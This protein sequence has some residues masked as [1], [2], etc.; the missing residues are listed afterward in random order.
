MVNDFDGFFASEYPLVV[1]ALALALGDRELAEDAAQEGFARALAHWATVSTKDR[2]TTWVYVVAM[3]RARDHL[4]HIARRPAPAPPAGL[5]D[6]A[7]AVATAVTVRAAIADLTPRQR[8]AVVLRYL[9][10]LT[11]QEM[12]VAMGCA[13]GTVKSTLHGALR[14]LRV[15]LRDQEEAGP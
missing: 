15:E 12:A 1:R 13:V 2:P 10:D 8:Q 9:A 4:R 7:G 11:V 3:N 14:S 6:P 5:G